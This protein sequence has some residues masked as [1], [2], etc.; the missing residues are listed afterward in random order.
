ME[1]FKILSLDGGGSW[2][3]IQI[4][5]LKKIYPEI[6]TG[7]ELLRKFDMAVSNSGGSLVL[8]AL[9]NDM[10]LDDIEK[11]FL[12]ENLRRK[13]FVRFD[14]LKRLKWSLPNWLGTGPRYDAKSKLDGLREVLNNVPSGKKYQDKKLH[15]IAPE[16]SPTF[17]FLIVTYDYYRNRASMMRSNLKSK[18]I[19]SNL[20][21]EN[22]KIDITGGTTL[23]EAGHASSNAPLNYFNAPAEIILD[24]RKTHCWDGAMAGYNNPLLAGITEAICNGVKLNDIC[25]LSIGTGSTFLPLR[26]MTSFKG[27]AK[28]FVEEKPSNFRSDIKKG[29]TSI[30]QDPPDAANFITYALLF[31][32][33]K[34]HK[35]ARFV[36]LSPTIQPELVNNVWQAPPS[37]DKEFEALVKLDM[38]AVEEREVKLIEKLCDE[39]LANNIPNQPIRIG[40]DLECLIGYPKFEEGKQAWLSNY[41]VG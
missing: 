12:D 17:Q 8:C 14:F 31:P 20:F 36:R 25:V 21:K 23:A 13:I 37:I 34:E 10:V 29:V 41:E 38:D 5:A 28:L 6:R 4:K 22:P 9:L 27:E 26:G 24:N 15:E 18:A 2:A 40:Q 32:E 16:I 1:S 30:L 33:L 7:H 35:E 11:V 3:L 39:W 19:A